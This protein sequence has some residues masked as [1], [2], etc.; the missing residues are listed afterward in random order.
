MHLYLRTDYL[1]ILDEPGAKEMLGAGVKKCR[2]IAG[3]T[4]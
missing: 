1:I 4:H 2:K 3:K